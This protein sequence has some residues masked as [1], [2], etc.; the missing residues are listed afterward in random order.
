MLVK[1]LVLD[2]SCNIFNQS[3]NFNTCDWFVH[4]LFIY[5]FIF[6]LRQVLVAS[7]RLFV[8]ACGIFPCGMQAIFLKCTDFSVVVVCKLQSEWAL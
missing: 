6:W 2:F 5:L 1:L 8:A 7:H 4:F 3:F